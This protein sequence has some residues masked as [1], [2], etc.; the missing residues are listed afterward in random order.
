M[1]A[2]RKLVFVILT[3]TGTASAL[4]DERANV[5]NDIAYAYALAWPCH[6]YYVANDESIEALA[7]AY[8]IDLARESLDGI[9]VDELARSYVDTLAKKFSDPRGFGDQNECAEARSA[10]PDAPLKPKQTP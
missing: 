4:A 8:Q 2:I 9:R 3:F 6:D 5:I 1:N 7:K 10:R